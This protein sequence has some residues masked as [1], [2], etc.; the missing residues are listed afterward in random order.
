MQLKILVAAA[1]LF[2]ATVPAVAKDKLPQTWDGLVEVDSKRLGAVY[3]APGADFRVY[4]R[5]MVDPTQ[6]AMKKNWAR[7]QNDSRMGV[8]RVTDKDVQRILQAAR[9]NYADVFQN[10]LT[11]AG[12]QLAT[13]PSPDVLRVAAA[14]INIDVTAPDVMSAGRSVSF[15]ADA[16]EATLVMEF[17]DSV[18]NA[19]LARVLDRRE[20]DGMPQRMNS[21]TNVA[22]FRQLFG[23]W[24]SAVV[25]GLEA[26][27]AH[28]PLPDPLTPGQKLQ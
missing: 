13:E 10:A 18:T 25:K 2:A 26:L 3:L 15:A 5:V 12:Y 28:S 1:A 6:V 20:T 21:V 14:I 27:K 22:E 24:S 4:Q 19:L 17:R 9:E 7:D 8:N 16:G 23:E 11:K